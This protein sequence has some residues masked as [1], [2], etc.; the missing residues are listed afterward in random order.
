MEPKT[1]EQ[2]EKVNEFAEDF[3]FKGY[4]RNSGEYSFFEIGI[5]SARIT[6]YYEIMNVGSAS[7]SIGWTS[8]DCGQQSIAATNDF[9]KFMGY[10]VKIAEKL[11]E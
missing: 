11:K 1:L 4:I 3:G 8:A 7:V 5:P 6:V 2:L 9:L 10:A